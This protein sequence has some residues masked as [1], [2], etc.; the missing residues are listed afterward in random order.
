VTDIRRIHFNRGWKLLPQID[1]E[2]VG[3]ASS[4]EKSIMPSGFCST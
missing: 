3:A 1:D 2:F 4:R